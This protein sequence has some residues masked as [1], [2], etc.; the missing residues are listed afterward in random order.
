MHL[1]WRVSGNNDAFGRVIRLMLHWPAKAANEVAN[2]L[3]GQKREKIRYEM[4][5][6]TKTARVAVLKK[7]KNKFAIMLNSR[8]SR[9]QFLSQNTILGLNKVWIM[10][11]REPCL[12]SEMMRGPQLKPALSLSL[13][14]QPNQAIQPKREE[15][16]AKQ[17]A[18]ICC[19]CCQT[20]S[21][22]GS[23]LR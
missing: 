20:I 4:L 12:K 15:E 6:R 7:C 16:I 2:L 17:F 13:S 8:K 21:D 18:T 1:I 5:D 11:T 22:P 23:A 14:L 3:C 9:M 10:Q 19:S